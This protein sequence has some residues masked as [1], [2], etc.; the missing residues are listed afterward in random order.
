MLAPANRLF[1]GGE[2]RA[3]PPLDEAGLQQHV[4]LRSVDRHGNVGGSLSGRAVALIVKRAAAR[5]GLDG[6]YS[7]LSLRAGFATA[8]ALAGLAPHAIMRQTRH[9]RA[10]SLDS[11]ATCR[12]A[13]SS[14]HRSIH[15]S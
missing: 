5:A 2:A 3:F 15:T 9:R 13:K 12:R 7:G 14:P 8:A 4:V 10:T 11:T 1:G 6:D